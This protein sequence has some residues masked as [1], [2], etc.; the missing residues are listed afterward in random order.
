M[1]RVVEQGTGSLASETKC[2]LED[3]PPK[4]RREIEAGA[5]CAREVATGPPRNMTERDRR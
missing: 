3:V 5:T 2:A 4:R 1:A